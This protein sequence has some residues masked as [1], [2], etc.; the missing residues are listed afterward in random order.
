MMRA[1]ISR[2]HA[3]V[4]FGILTVFNL[5]PPQCLSS[6]RDGPLPSLIAFGGAAVKRPRAREMGIEVGILPP[7]QFNAITDV[8][9]VLVGHATVDRGADVRTGVT[10]VMPHGGNLFRE[11]VRAGAFVGNGFGKAAG[12]SQVQELGTIET[13]IGLTS[14]LN[15]PEV[16]AALID[17]T[18]G[19]PG[20]EDVTS[21]NPVVG[22]TNDG[23]LNAIRLRPVRA[24][25]ALSAIA[26]ARS[27]PVEEGSVGAGRGT[28]CFGFKGGIGTA[29]RVV[30]TG[31]GAFTVGALVQA[32]FGGILQVNGAPI[33]RELGKYYRPPD[34]ERGSCIIII[35]TDAPCGSVSLERMAKRAIAAMARTGAIFS[36]GSGDYAIAFSSNERLRVR[37]DRSS[38]APR[39]A[40]IEGD[41]LTPFFLAVQEAT[42]E[43]IYNALLTAESVCGWRGRCVEAIP[44]DSVG[45]ICEKYGV[46]HLSRK[47]PTAAPKR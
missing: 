21:V 24:E 25:D 19:R 7:G 28:V 29:S 18:L 33:G 26:N 10:I 47:L 37:L 3:A 4:F 16:S 15:V 44:V 12:L 31:A 38:P 43:A 30:E 8:P 32:N 40:E 2:L 17:Y 13:P 36:N 22:E 23:Y 42:E 39:C 14:T 11:K 5:V 9:G 35:A 1:D 6:D 45:A 41:A 27:G 34:A 20:N 46:L